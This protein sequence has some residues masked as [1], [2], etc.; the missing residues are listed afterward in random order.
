M[1]YGKFRSTGRG[2]PAGWGVPG[3]QRPGRRD[4]D[5][6]REAART[7]RY[8]V[9]HPEPDGTWTVRQ[10]DG[11][12]GRLG[13]PV[14][15][16]ESIGA[17]SDAALA[18]AAELVDVVAWQSMRRPYAGAFIDETFSLV[19]DIARQPRPGRA[20]VARIESDPSIPGVPLLTVRERWAAT[21]LESDP[22]YFCQYEGEDIPAQVGEWFGLDP[23]GWTA[24]TPGVEFW[25]RESRSKGS[26]QG[27]QEV[28]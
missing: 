13:E 10:L 24:V 16:S 15:T 19:R 2:R 12:T 1:R 8:W 14:H 27:G 23:S 18:W 21:G 26:R 7:D 5:L 11:G 25:Y 17:D 4:V 9:L 6:I 22:L 20:V 3:A 28:V